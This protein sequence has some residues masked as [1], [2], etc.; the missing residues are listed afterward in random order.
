MARGREAVAKLV[1]LAVKRARADLARLEERLAAYE[2]RHTTSSPEF[3]AKF[4]AGE[5][6]DD[7]DAVEW[8]ILWE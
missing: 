2:K 7:M 8:S 6:G 4:R 1:T 3:Y 5:M